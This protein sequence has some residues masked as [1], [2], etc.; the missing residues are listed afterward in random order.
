MLA[1]LALDLG[2]ITDCGHND[3]SFRTWS[4]RQISLR[5]QTIGLIFNT[6]TPQL[7]EAEPGG[8]TWLLYLADRHKLYIYRY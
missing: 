5:Y 3:I 8:E 7:G 6:L 4:T 2:D 1:V